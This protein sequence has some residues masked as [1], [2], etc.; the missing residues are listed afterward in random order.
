MQR[1]LSLSFSLLSI[2]LSRCLHQCM[3]THLTQQGGGYDTGFGAGKGHAASS[4]SAGVLSSSGGARQ[5]SKDKLESKDGECK[6][7]DV[8]EEAL[9]MLMLTHKGDGG[10]GATRLA[11]ASGGTGSTAHLDVSLHLGSMTV[12][13]QEEALNTMALLF[14]RLAAVYSRYIPHILKCPLYS[15]FIYEIY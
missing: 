14:A 9:I 1:A 10:Q 12:C 8:C 7:G 3:D 6:G 13:H 5:A 11:Q 4:A 15:D 2:Y